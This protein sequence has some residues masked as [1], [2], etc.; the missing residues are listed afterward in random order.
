MLSTL[1]CPSSLCKPPDALLVELI[2]TT[3][4]C[5]LSRCG[6]YMEDGDPVDDPELV[7]KHYATGWFPFDCI[8][9]F[10][11]T[12]IVDSDLFRGMKLMRLS[13]LAKMEM[14]EQRIIDAL[15]LGAK[16]Q[17][18]LRLLKLGFYCVVCGHIAACMWY[19]IA[20]LEGH[21]DYSWTQLYLGEETFG[22]DGSPNA[23]SAYVSALYWAAAT[24][25]TVGY[26]DVS[27]HTD[28][29]RGFALLMIVVGALIFASMVGKMVQMANAMYE[30]ERALQTRRTQISGFLRHKKVPRE[31]RTKVRE[32]Y[33]AL[34]RRGL[35]EDEQQMFADMPPPLR[36]EILYSMH[37]NLFEQVPVLKYS[38]IGLQLLVAERLTT[39]LVLAREYVIIGGEAGRFMYFIRSGSL[40]SIDSGGY[41]HRHHDVGSFFGEAAM[42]DHVPSQESVRAVTDCELLRLSRDDFLDILVDFPEWEQ[43]LRN[44]VLIRQSH[45]KN[46]GGEY[47]ARVKAG[48]AQEHGGANAAPASPKPRA[49]SPSMAAAG[50]TRSAMPA[51]RKAIV[52][53]DK[54]T[55]RRRHSGAQTPPVGEDSW[56]HLR[57]GLGQF[58]QRYLTVLRRSRTLQ[59]DTY[60]PKPRS[61]RRIRLDPSLIS[62]VDAIAANG[63][64]RWVTQRAAAGW[65]WGPERDNSR[66]LHPD[67][68]PFDELDDDS[69]TFNIVAAEKV[70]KL[71]VSEGFAIRKPF[72]SESRLKELMSAVEGSTVIHYVRRDGRE[73]EYVPQPLDL[74]TVEL[75]V[76]LDSLVAFCSEQAHDTWAR[77][78]LDAGWVWGHHCDDRAKTHNL[79]VP[80]GFLSNEQR[81][82]VSS[83]VV[84]ILKMA[85]ALGYTFAVATDEERRAARVPRRGARRRVSTAR[86]GKGGRRRSFG[87]SATADTTHFEKL[88]RHGALVE[89]E[90]ML[91]DDRAQRRSSGSGVSDGGASESDGWTRTPRGVVERAAMSS[92]PTTADDD[93]AGEVPNAVPS[94]VVAAARPH[95]AG[96]GGA[97]TKWRLA[98]KAAVTKASPGAA[99]GG[100]RTLRGASLAAATSPARKPSLFDKMREMGVIGNKGGGQLAAKVAGSTMGGGGGGG[101]ADASAL[102]ETNSR[103]AVLE[104]KVDK[105]LT[106]LDRLPQLMSAM[107]K[108]DAAAVAATRLLQPE[109][110]DSTR[111]VDTMQSM[112]AESEGD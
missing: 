89:E 20:S 45:S 28:A 46:H 39:V 9:S 53:A 44:V 83:G 2:E 14:V 68:I 88:V 38:Q 34:Y 19:Y 22:P 72:D 81:D 63:H 47:F 71:V 54:N 1:C 73:A 95:G 17:H 75:P 80:F 74:S 58:E 70:L 41:I 112:D 29:E 7:I 66:Q 94:S 64:D 21:G 84:G 24:L 30:R 105:I 23:A 92:P 8:A 90:G 3:N 101:A 79:L 77:Q 111:T 100:N 13:R 40:V 43:T 108:G 15:D 93:G 11:Y 76:E 61:L 49:G 106:A 67:M 82:D 59:A 85:V 6:R 104:G 35:D 48:V 110:G 42:L 12:V 32:A 51:P 16:R 37:S 31:L 97:G 96:S 107:V 55:V 62:L 27:A 50:S 86:G 102:Q 18:Q 103:V 52:A 56:T 10:P 69:R 26:G 99:D 60:Q 109:V 4:C 33:E 57:D 87:R 98:A 91:D 65:Q 78:R 5:N 25:T 36:R